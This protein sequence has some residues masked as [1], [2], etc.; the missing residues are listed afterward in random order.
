MRSKGR[1]W[2]EQGCN[3]LIE[4]AYCRL[5]HKS[6]ATQATAKENVS[7][8]IVQCT[9]MGMR[10]RR[11]MLRD[12]SGQLITPKREK[13]AKFIL[14]NFHEIR[15]DPSGEFGPLGGIVLGIKNNEYGVSM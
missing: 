1:C 10:H 8:C 4:A 13:D 12:P 9:V 5:V 15:F 6:A 2:Q 14:E 3:R 11:N 7:V